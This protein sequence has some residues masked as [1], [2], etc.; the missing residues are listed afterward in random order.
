MVGTRQALAEGLV[1]FGVFPGWSVCWNPAV[2]D[3]N[4]WLFSE[5]TGAPFSRCVRCDWPLAEIAAPWLV[6]KEYVGCECVLEYAVCKP[7]R[8]SVTDRFSEE[9]KESVR[10]F[11]EMEIDWEARTREFMMAAN[12]VERFAA[13]ISC[14]TPREQMGRFAISALYDSGGHLVSGALPLLICGE[15]IAKVTAGLSEESRQIWREFIRDHF[16]GPDD[17]TDFDDD[18]LGI[19]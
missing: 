15:C 2:D 13:C 3:I 18:I 5:E 10:V 19:F 16:R 6:N 4:R 1:T 12:P 7:C 14:R 8:D 9:S 17:D 11:L